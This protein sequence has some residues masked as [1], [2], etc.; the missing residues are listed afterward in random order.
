MT[1]GLIVSGEEGRVQIDSTYKNYS[2]IEEGIATASAGSTTPTLKP[3]EGYSFQDCLIFV[4]LLADG[5]SLTM[6]NLLPT[7]AIIR[8]YVNRYSTS[9]SYGYR[10]Y[11]PVE[12]DTTSNDFGMQVWSDGGQLV[13][14]S[15]RETLAIDHFETVN[16]SVGFSPLALSAAGQTAWVCISPMNIIIG[17]RREDT[18]YGKQY[19]A[20]QPGFSRT[21]GVLQLVSHRREIYTGEPVQITGSTPLSVLVGYR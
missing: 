15:R 10:I 21:G 13:Y 16:I 14:D 3:P 20:Y 6:Y 8:G 1:F 5:D 11:A 17:Y 12:P 2:L 7:A 4:R 19:I 9:I 18:N